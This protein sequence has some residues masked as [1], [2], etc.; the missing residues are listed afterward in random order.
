MSHTR[1]QVTF[2]DDCLVASITPAQ[3]FERDDAIQT[4][5]ARPEDIA[6]RAAADLV[7]KDEWAP[8]DRWL[9]VTSRCELGVQKLE[10]IMKRSTQRVG[11]RK[12]PMQLSEALDDAPVDEKRG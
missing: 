3:Q 7:E 6:V 2:L 1:E 4:S 11:W 5:V 9:V 12:A 8:G 10:G